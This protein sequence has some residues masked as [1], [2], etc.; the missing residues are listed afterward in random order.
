MVQ[1]NP[2]RNK[3]VRR[4]MSEQKAGTQFG[5][6]PRQNTTQPVPSWEDLSPADQAKLI[7]TT[8]QDKDPAAIARARHF[9]GQAGKP[10]RDV[11]PPRYLG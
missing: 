10:L 8:G 9:H 1:R 6:A 2:R 4:P 7:K 3:G 11:P 5:G